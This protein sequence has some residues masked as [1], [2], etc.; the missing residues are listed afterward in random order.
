MTVDAYFGVKSHDLDQAGLWI[1]AVTGLPAEPRESI[2]LG[3]SYLAFRGRAGE[4]LTLAKNRD[5]YDGEPVF[6]VGS[7]WLLVLLVERA[8]DG[9]PLLR[10]L[11]DVP[12]RLVRLKTIRY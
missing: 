2:Q 7:N 8:D 11:E 9:S 10:A 3:G 6:D 12:E 4:K 5:V 1:E